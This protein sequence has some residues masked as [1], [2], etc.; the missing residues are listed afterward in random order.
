MRPDLAA[1]P[2]AAASTSAAV[3]KPE[4]TVPAPMPQTPQAS[5]CPI[6]NGL[7]AARQIPRRVP[8]PVLR[9]ALDL[10]R[11]TGV[12]FQAGDR[13]IIAGDQG[14]GKNSVA[15][16]LGYRLRPRQ[17]KVLLLNC[18]APETAE[19][20]VAE[21]LQDGPVAGVYFLTGLDNAPAIA[22]MT[23]AQWS[24]EQAKRAKL[25]Y[26]IMRQL[27]ENTFLVCAT[28]MGGLH[29][30][31]QSEAAVAAINPLGGAVT[32]FAKAYAMERRET[33][34]KAIDVD[35]DLDERKIAAILIDETL[36]DPGA[37]EIGYHDGRRFGIALTEQTVDDEKFDLRLNRDTVFL[38]TGGAGG[39][40]APIVADLACASAGTFYLTGRTALPQ[41][42][43]ANPD[44]A[45]LDGDERKYLKRDIA[46]RL[47]ESG[48][49][50]TPVLVEQELA[51]LERQ[52]SI[53]KVVE[54]VE[55]NGGAAHYRACD[56]TDAQAV[57]AL[58]EDIR[59]TH[60][61]LDIVIHAAGIERSHPLD[62]KSA[63]EFDLVYGIKADGFFNLLKAC[64]SLPQAPRAV[65]VFSSIAGRFGN[66]G[67]TDYSAANDLMCKIVASMRTTHPDTKAIAI[68]WSAWAKV[69]M[70]T[71]G[72]IPEIMQ[73]AGIEML[74]PEHAAPVVRR[75]ITV[76]GAGGETV[77]AHALGLLAQAR[78]PDGGIDLEQANSAIGHDLAFA[79]RVSGLD[80][81]GEFTF[82]SELDPQQE[83][84]LRDHAIDGTPLL[85]GVIGVEGFAQV[86]R[87]VVSKLGAPDAPCRIAAIED[88]HFKA[89][90]KFYRRQPR[91]LT[92]R[93]IVTPHAGGLTARVRLE[94]VRQLKGG[95]EQTL[96]FVGC[97]HLVP[98]D[99]GEPGPVMAAVPN[100][101]GAA[102]VA[103]D[104]IYRVYFHGPAFQ[105]LAG[106]EVIAGRA[107]GKFSVDLPP[108]LSSSTTG[109][110]KKTLTPPR[111]VELCLQTAGVWE[112][113]KTGVMA[114]PVAID[115][116]VVH[117]AE[118]NGGPLYAEMTPRE[119]KKNR[120]VF[121]G[122]VVDAQGRVY[123]E[124]QGY[125]TARLSK[126]DQEQLLAPLR[127]IV[128]E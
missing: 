83:P 75:E 84:F 44:L 87:L 77:A 51:R 92:W 49:R 12:T 6:V 65:V 85:P 100:W 33:L 109:A 78:A 121:D 96:H 90:L 81:S 105:V 26:A 23:P 110:V 101:S 94:S 36:N 30:Y 14:R 10:C 114:L 58:V 124:M 38:I 3:E 71:R 82:Q 66:A 112:I 43:R 40:S 127:K 17:V 61:K 21:W 11:P 116:M 118:V 1:S 47:K 8:V 46:K 53:L 32:G 107:V 29:G 93:V 86:A 37:V 76:A 113:G 67:Q 24:A 35:G 5:A 97:V 57:A 117:C 80:T 9:P 104:D 39:I 74:Q 20:Q 91:T 69:G 45:R 31:G 28:R 99:Q 125:H 70:A 42:G 102:A 98:G 16:Y 55:Q 120:L 128:Q 62:R 64:Q 48:L 123:L 56:V 15:K 2:Q 50:P 108:M 106:V 89:A 63:D 52:K 95:A 18:A 34:V 126:L 59:Q 119:G 88:V 122:R 115:R 111:L 79:G 13:V 68:D 60:G 103:P 54:Q 73:R 19:N 22:E 25:L 4:P 72:S 7:K 41:D 27:S